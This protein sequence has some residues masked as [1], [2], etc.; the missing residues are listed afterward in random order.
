MALA[1]TSPS[2]YTPSVA[3]NSLRLCSGQA[4]RNRNHSAQRRKEH[5]L[6]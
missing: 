3:R 2:V 1:S 6:R 5:L 4:F